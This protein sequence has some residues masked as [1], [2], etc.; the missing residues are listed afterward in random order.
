ME[1]YTGVYKVSNI[2]ANID[3]DRLLLCFYAPKMDGSRQHRIPLSDILC[4]E[5]LPK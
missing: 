3:Q 4:W 5:V 2:S 1:E